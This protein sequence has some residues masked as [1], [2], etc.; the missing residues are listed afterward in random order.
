MLPHHRQMTELPT[1]DKLSQLV[2]LEFDRERLRAGE[3]MAHEL[4]R[5]LHVTNPSV[6]FVIASV[7]GKVADRW[8]EGE[9]LSAEAATGL[10]RRLAPS[11]NELL[12]AVR[13]PADPGQ[14]LDCM[15]SLVRAYRD[16]VARQR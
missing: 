11:I 15:N 10:E 6:P 13:R 2:T 4:T 12:D 7:L 1:Y 9:A 8:F 5:S 14:L 3:R 16:C